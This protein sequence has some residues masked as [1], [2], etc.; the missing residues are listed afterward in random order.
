MANSQYIKTLQ[1]QHRIFYLMK[2][3]C[4]FLNVDSTNYIRTL[5]TINSLWQL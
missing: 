2:S 1:E 3:I 5:V 4:K